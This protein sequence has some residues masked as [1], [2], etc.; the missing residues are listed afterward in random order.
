MSHVPT[1]LKSD[2]S[3]FDKM[4]PVDDNGCPRIYFF[5]TNRRQLRFMSDNEYCLY[6][7]THFAYNVDSNVMRKN[8]FPTYTYLRRPDLPRKVI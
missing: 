5:S 3:V 7:P 2:R 4:L 6:I 1:V 8:A